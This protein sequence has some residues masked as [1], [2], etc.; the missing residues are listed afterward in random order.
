MFESN[1]GIPIPSTGSNA[2][3][4]AGAGIGSIMG[5][6][7]TGV[8]SALGAGAGRGIESL[9]GYDQYEEAAR[10][11]DTMYP[12]TNPHER[13]G[14][15]GGGSP[16]MASGKSEGDKRNAASVKIAKIGAD[17]Q[18]YASDNQR[19]AADQT[20][21][22]AKD[23]VTTEIEEMNARIK[24]MSTNDQLTMQ[25]TFAET[26]RVV[27]EHWKAATSEDDAEARVAQNHIQKAMAKYAE[28]AARLSGT[29]STPTSAIW[30][31][32]ANNFD[33]NKAVYYTA[34]K[35]VQEGWYELMEMKDKSK[36]IEEPQPVP[37]K[38]WT[39]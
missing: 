38:P 37:F 13:L 33:F 7:G 14:A 35:A 23:K 29:P 6:I 2:G 12:G 5:P 16:G 36:S 4:M 25:K 1:N 19:A 34:W 15:A 31:G 28:E 30:A 22:I 8:G 10:G 32:G 17:A 27:Q 39:P 24:N 9:L 18:K 11:M 21:G 20:Y 3:A 26:Q